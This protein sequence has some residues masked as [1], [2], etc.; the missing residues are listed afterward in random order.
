MTLETDRLL[1]RDLRMVDLDDFHSYRADPEIA[2]YQEYEVMDRTMAAEFIEK[3]ARLDDHVHLHWK[4]YGIE[5]KETA[6]LIGDSG[7]MIDRENEFAHIG[8]TIAHS[9]QRN[10]YAKEVLLGLMSHL[11][12]TLQLHRIVEIVDENNSASIAL[13]K[14]AGFRQEGH[15]IEH[16]FFKGRWS[17]EYQFAMLRREWE[18][19]HS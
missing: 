12:D 17:S 16:V 13:L 15:F 10:G 11:F 14:S 9:A 6:Q 5:L 3:H 2:R 4:Q 19:H 1:L 7:I 18:A 8:I